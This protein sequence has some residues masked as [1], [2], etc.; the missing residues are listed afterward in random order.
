M[1][2]YRTIHGVKKRGF[3]IQAKIPKLSDTAV[4][5]ENYTGEPILWDDG[6]DI[7]WDDG[8]QILWSTEA[9]IYARVI[10]GVKK[11]SLVIR[12]KVTHA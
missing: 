5:I 3:V 9:S 12:A 2:D 1:T 11:R 8:T 4:T 10:S 7:Q 6:T